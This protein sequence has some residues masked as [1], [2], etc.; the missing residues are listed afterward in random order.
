[1][2]GSLACQLFRNSDFRRL[3]LTGKLCHARLY[4]ST[5]QIL[6][7]QVASRG[8]EGE[9]PQ[10]PLGF[11]FDPSSSYYYNA[12]SGMYYDAKSGAYFSA[13][14][15]QWYSFDTT[16]QTYVRAT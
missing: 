5:I 6:Q 15:G 8:P 11:V 1:M 10:V 13:T 2:T 7:M 3:R 9:Q 12:E 4:S 16:L 14:D